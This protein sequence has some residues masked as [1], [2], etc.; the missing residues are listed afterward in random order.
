MTN[1]KSAIQ[2][3]RLSKRIGDRRVLREIDLE[4]AEGE[5][6]ALTGSNGTGKTTLLR[7]LSAIARPTSGKVYWFGRPAAADPAQRRLIG[8]VSHESRLY[9]HLTLRENLVFA[10]RLFSVADPGERAEQLLKQIGLVSLAD[11]QVGQISRGMGQ[12]LALA[13]ALIHDPPILLLDEP[14]SGLDRSSRDWLARLLHERREQGR[15]LC[16][17]THDEQQTGQIADRTLTL[18]G[19]FL[20]GHPVVADQSMEENR[21]RHAA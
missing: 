19:G 8:M 21:H 7:C 15:T 14:F 10:A 17:S 18:S 5:C 4:I 16:F 1:Q 2:A 20:T 11:R 12:R 13:R 9:A 6:V 3:Q